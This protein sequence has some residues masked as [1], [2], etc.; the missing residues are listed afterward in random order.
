MTWRYQSTSCDTRQHTHC[1][2]FKCSMTA[3]KRSKRITVLYYCHHTTPHHTHTLTRAR[4]CMCF[5]H[6]TNNLTWWTSTC[7]TS[8]AEQPP[9]TCDLLTTRCLTNRCNFPMN[10]LK[11][12]SIIA[13]IRLPAEQPG[14]EVGQGMDVLS[15]PSR[16]GPGLKSPSNDSKE[17]EAWAWR[18]TSKQSRAWERIEL[19]LHSSTRFH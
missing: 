1:K 16:H 13:I 17:A 6:T 10:S 9:A 12:S 7:E 11:S 3:H 15:S 2:W 14:F 18:L 8:P 4:V 5:F 19:Y